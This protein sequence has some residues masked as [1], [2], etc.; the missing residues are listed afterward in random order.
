MDAKSEEAEA[1]D[2]KMK[3]ADLLSRNVNAYQKLSVYVVPV[4]GNCKNLQN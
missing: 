3:V 1:Q 2:K 4:L